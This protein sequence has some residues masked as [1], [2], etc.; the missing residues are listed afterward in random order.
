MALLSLPIEL[1]Y[2]ISE[3]ILP[4]KFLNAFVQTNRQ[5][6]QLFNHYLYR[7]DREHCGSSALLKAA[8]RGNLPA[9]RKY[10]EEQRET[11]DTTKIQAAIELAVEN[12]R[13]SA[14]VL[15]LRHGADVNAEVDYFGNLLQLSAWLGDGEMMELLIDHG[16][17]VHAQGGHYGSALQAASWTGTE[18]MVQ[19]LLQRGADVN[20]QGGYFGNALQGA[21]WIGKKGIVLLLLSHGAT[22]DA[23]AGFYGTALQAASARGRTDIVQVLLS[24][25][26]DVDIQ[27]GYYSTAC[28]AASAKGHFRVEGL[29]RYWSWR[30]RHENFLR[31]MSL[32]CC[33][34]ERLSL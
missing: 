13:H 25:G 28:K 17:N 21:S 12:S 3:H 6:Y 7:Y 2:E 16:A 27:G 14:V 33:D 11:P 20:A 34:L 1:L 9:L 29:L 24:N 8:T 26:A 15:L 32:L 10:F 5:C 19:V 4:V 31:I 22:I 23:L 18:R 30:Q